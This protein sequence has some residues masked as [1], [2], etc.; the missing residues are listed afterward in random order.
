MPPSPTETSSTVQRYNIIHNLHL[1]NCTIFYNF[2]LNGSYYMLL[3]LVMA[4]N[5]SNSIIGLS[6]PAAGMVNF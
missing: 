6:W 2:Y 3:Y 4:M 1:K 5:I